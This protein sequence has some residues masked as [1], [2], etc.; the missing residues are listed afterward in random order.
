MDTGHRPDEVCQLPRPTRPPPATP[1]V[2]EAN[3]LPVARPSRGGLGYL[4]AGDSSGR[5]FVASAN[6]QVSVYC[7]HR[8][9]LPPSMSQT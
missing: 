5:M 3:P 8:T 9:I 6:A 1:T 2:L 7:C 4:A